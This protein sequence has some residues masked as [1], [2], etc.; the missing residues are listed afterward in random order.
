VIEKKSSYARQQMVWA[1]IWVTRGG[2]VGRSPLVIMERDTTSQR[3]GYS[4]DSYISTLSDGLLPYYNPM[5]IFMQD[6]APIHKAKKTRIWLETYRIWT[7]DFPLYL[8][9]LNPIEHMW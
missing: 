9:D 4:A 7:M 1:S 5:D 2:R 6:N 3:R 8:P